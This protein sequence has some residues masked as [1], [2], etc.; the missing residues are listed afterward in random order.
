MT[1]NIFDACR[2]APAPEP[3]TT[4]EP[5]CGGCGRAAWNHP[6]GHC[7]G[8]DA[9]YTP[10]PGARPTEDEDR[11]GS[12]P[13]ELDAELAAIV[14]ANDARIAALPFDL[15]LHAERLAGAMRAYPS[16][17]DGFKDALTLVFLAAQWRDRVTALW[18]ELN[19]AGAANHTTGLARRRT[20]ARTDASR[21]EI[22]QRYSRYL[23]R[24][25]QRNARFLLVDHVGQPLHP[26]LVAL[27]RPTTP[28][29]Y[30][31]SQGACDARRTSTAAR[32][33][34]S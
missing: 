20:W 25:A 17:A 5:P 31:R 26:T 27:I 18:V 32:R 1:A 15:R 14:A 10:E 6:D 9:S 8:S 7:H 21:I 24:W 19:P 30:S 12:S 29:N 22:E 2:F 4:P 3:D 13:A 11:E 16:L 28:G 23:W 33:M 34:A